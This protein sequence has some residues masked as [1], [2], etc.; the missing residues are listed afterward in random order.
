MLLTRFVATRPPFLALDDVYAIEGGVPVTV[1]G[2]VV[3]AVG[4]SGVTS[5]QDA[6]VAAAGAAAVVP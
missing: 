5:Q 2:R 4:V 1:N 6:V 3:G